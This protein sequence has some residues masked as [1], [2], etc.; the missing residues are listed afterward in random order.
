MAAST[1]SKPKKDKKRPVHEIRI[2]RIR[3]AIWENESENGTFHNVTLSRLYKDDDDQWRDSA[4]FSRDDLPLVAKVCD[5][6]HSWIFQQA[7][8]KNGGNGAAEGRQPGDE[9][10]PY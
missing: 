7:A 9:E 1:K 10:V 5:Q 8:E 6:V 3:A 2:G 4:S